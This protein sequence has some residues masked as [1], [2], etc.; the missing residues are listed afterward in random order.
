M[1]NRSHSGAIG[2]PWHICGRC[3]CDFRVSQLQWQNGLLVCKDDYDN[4]IA[5]QR[6]T[7]IDE[8]LSGDDGTEADVAEILK[9]H[10]NE[11]E[12]PQM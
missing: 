6:Q 3:G 4:P 8:A 5:W 2:D 7:M 10:D 11:P 12:P 9:G 1:P